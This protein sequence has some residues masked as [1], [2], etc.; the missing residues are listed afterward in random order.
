M[1]RALV[2]CVLP[3]VI[4]VVAVVPW[5]LWFDR[6]PDPLAIHWSGS[7]PEGTASRVAALGLSVVPAAVAAVALVMFVRRRPT[8]AKGLWVFLSSFLGALSAAMSSL[9]VM[10]N[11]DAASWQD[12]SLEWWALV[13][14]VAA[15]IAIGTLAVAWTTL[16]PAPPGEALVPATGPST[17]LLVGPGE[18]GA[19]SG[20]ARSRWAW[21]FAGV[22]LA[23]AVVFAFVGSWWVAALSAFLAAIAGLFVTVRV[24][25]DDYG[26][27]VRPGGVRWP[28]VHISLQRIASAEA[29]DVRPMRWGGWGYR[30]SL[31]LMRQAAWVLRAGPGIKLTLTNGSVFVVTVDGADT[32]TAVLND[33][34]TATS[35]H[36]PPRPG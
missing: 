11:L 29:I 18:Q 10:F 2:G 4:V 12:A 32:G 5:L 9:T 30:G 33:L 25:T 24:T 23:A 36:Q 13:L 3:G 16:P 19:W 20:T 1:K 31:R 6:L 21:P 28:S 34:T 15:P 35:Q 17:V 22:F 14:A 8:P 7:R 27:R 26:L